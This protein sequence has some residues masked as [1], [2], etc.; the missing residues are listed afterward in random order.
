MGRRTAVHG[1]TGGR[2]ADCGMWNGGKG[3][4]VRWMD[5]QMG[6]RTGRRAI[7][8]AG[9]RAGGTDRRKGHVMGGRIDV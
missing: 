9:R 7:L 2:N 3:D 5:E 1:R 8:W 4:R 6:E